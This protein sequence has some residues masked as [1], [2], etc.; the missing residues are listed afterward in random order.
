MPAGKLGCR[1][2]DPS[3][4]ILRLEDYLIPAQLPRVLPGADVDYCSHVPSWPMY[5]NGPDPENAI[6]CPGS[7]DGCGDCVWALQGH[8]IQAWTAYSGTGM[9]TIPASSVIAGYATTGYDPQTG[10]GDNGTDMQTALQYMVTHGL[11]DGSGKI[12][13]IA[14]YALMSE[15][16]DE[17]L[18]AQV[19]TIGGTVALAANLQQAQEDQSNAGQPWDYVPGSPVI[20][21]HAFCLQ[22]R[23][24]TGSGRRQN[25]SW[26]MVQPATAAFQQQCV[27]EGYYVV[28]QDFL[29]ESGTSPD[30]LNLQ[31]M[32]A[33]MSAVS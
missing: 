13:R 14:A 20:G 7:P 1:P 30:G 31:Q 6:V 5:C 11:P 15:P 8:M 27:T 4:H 10:A 19:L 33:D 32:L 12:R 17:E 9:V 29:E 18:L 28:S 23:L 16:G 2:R 21:G 25:I 24:G 22:R 26:G 3:R